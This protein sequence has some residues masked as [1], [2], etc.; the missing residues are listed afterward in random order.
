MAKVLIVDDEQALCESLAEFLSSNGNETETAYD[1][2]EAV[3]KLP[4]FRP[5]IVLLDIR[6][7]GMNGLE[8]LAHIKAFDPNIRIIMVTAVHEE[9]VAQMAVREGA[10]EYITKPVDLEHLQTMVAFQEIEA[11]G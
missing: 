4:V 9:D 10:N 11:L 3:D 5:Q 6:M 2:R 1:G 7:P 8:A